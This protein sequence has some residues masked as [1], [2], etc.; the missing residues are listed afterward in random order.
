[1]AR[2]SYLGQ[3]GAGERQAAQQ[4]DGFH[5]KVSYH[6][7]QSHVQGVSLVPRGAVKQLIWQT[8]IHF[9]TCKDI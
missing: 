2:V 7:P 8:V 9:Y 6:V 5:V 3:Q 1:M 4:C